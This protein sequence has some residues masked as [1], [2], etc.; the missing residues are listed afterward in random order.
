MPHAF[1]IGGTGQIGLATSEHLLDNGWTVTAARRGSRP[2]PPALVARGVN[3]VT[4]D[5]DEPNE[6]VRALSAGADVLIDAVAYG[7]EHARQLLGVQ[8]SVGSLIVISSSSVYRDSLG[9]TLDEALETG[10]PELPDPIAED[11]VTVDPGPETYSTRK[12][13]LER[14]L[15]DEAVAPLTILRPA[16]I[17]GPGSQHAREWWFVK[18]M[19]DG[20]SVIP[21]AYLGRSRF[22]VTSAANIAGL[23]LLCA[24][25]PGRR[26]LNIADPV[27]PTVSEIANCIGGHFGYTGRI[28]ELP[29]VEVY[30]PP[31]GRTPWSVQRPFVLDTAAATALGYRPRAS[32]HETVAKVCDWLVQVTAGRDWR[33]LLPTL[34]SYPYDLFDYPSEDAALATVR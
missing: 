26:V 6:W 21:V 28:L 8:G 29:D 14:R 4:M 20:R 31:I 19:L 5:R 25:L 32:Y 9:R 1:I 33:V 18:R 11:Q 16:A 13:A 30:P 27:A 10:F 2:M 23:V 12:I 15:L 34:A 7:P 3:T 24:G 17:S 22:H